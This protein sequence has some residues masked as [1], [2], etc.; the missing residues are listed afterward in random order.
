MARG[1][2]SILVLLSHARAFTIDDYNTI[3]HPGIFE[4]IFYFITSLGHESVIVFFVLSGFLI[5]MSVENQFHSGRFNL[6][7][8]TSDRLSRL[9]TVLIPALAITAALDIATFHFTK[10]SFYL[11]E[12]KFLNSGPTGH[13]EWG[14]STLMGNIFFTQGV[15]VHV[16][17]SNTPLWSLACEFWY[18]VIFPVVFIATRRFASHRVVLIA[19]SAIVISVIG[20]Y[21]N[22]AILK[23]YIVWIF[24]YLSFIFSKG[25]NN[26]KIENKLKVL[27]PILIT[28]IILIFYFKYKNEYLKD[29]SLGLILSMVMNMSSN[30]TM[31]AHLKSISEFTSKI[32]YSLYLV[33]FPLLAS[34]FAFICFG[35]RRP[36]EDG[37]VYFTILTVISLLAG[38]LVYAAFESKTPVVKGWIQK[39]LG[40]SPR[41]AQS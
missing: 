37:L 3:S 17:G 18:Y 34:L 23:Y 8:Y 19:L 27:L 26:S 41:N 2:A 10:S 32:S 24:G 40:I 29:L 15:L 39:F 4:K 6:K 5:T 36:L 1:A 31:S 11:G 38:V 9:W 16:Y 25:D 33:H 22:N 35:K 7:K 30:I 14:L 20:Y 12:F 28:L 21:V 13:A